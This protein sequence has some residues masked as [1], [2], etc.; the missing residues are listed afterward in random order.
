MDLDTRAVSSSNRSSQI[1]MSDLRFS[2]KSYNV[3]ICFW[4][5]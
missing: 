3:A 4:W 5:R 2:V 1:R